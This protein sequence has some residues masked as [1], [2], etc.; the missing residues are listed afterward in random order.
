MALEANAR[1]VHSRG[2]PCGSPRS[3]CLRTPAPGDLQTNRAGLRCRLDVFWRFLLVECMNHVANLRISPNPMGDPSQ[4]TPRRVTGQSLNVCHRAR[5]PEPRESWAPVA[6]AALRPSRTG[7]LWDRDC[8]LRQPVPIL[9]SLGT[10]AMSV[11]SGPPDRLRTGSRRE[12]PCAP[13][14]CSICKLHTVFRRDGR[15]HILRHIRGQ[16]AQ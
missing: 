6:H 9:F 12:S 13:C 10:P 4:V 2:G 1:C 11:A 16:P 14:P 15:L 3:E 8:P 5:S 7:A